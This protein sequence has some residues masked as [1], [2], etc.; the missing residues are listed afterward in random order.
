MEDR[1]IVIVL[2]Q[3]V[4]EYNHAFPEGGSGVALPSH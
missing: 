1:S 2:K 4:W 3:A